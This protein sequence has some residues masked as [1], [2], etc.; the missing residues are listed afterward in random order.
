MLV[1]ACVRTCRMRLTQRAVDLVCVCLCVCLCIRMI[2]VAR[3]VYDYSMHVNWSLGCISV[4]TYSQRVVWLSWPQLGFVQTQAGVAKKWWPFLL[5][6]YLL[7]L[8]HATTQKYNFFFLFLA[9]FLSH[10]LTYK[11]L[12]TCKQTCGPI[13]TGQQR[14]PGCCPTFW[15]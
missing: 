2:Q 10:T 11:H 5:C 4:N 7:S 15:I 1:L 14:A 8:Q 9:F 12:D 3:N 13:V 6:L